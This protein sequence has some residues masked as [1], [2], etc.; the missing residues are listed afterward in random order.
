MEGLWL[1]Q[2]ELE[3]VTITPCRKCSSFYL[4]NGGSFWM[5]KDKEIIARKLERSYRDLLR[6]IKYYDFLFFMLPFL[7]LLKGILLNTG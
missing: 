3:G 7:T 5:S 6:A 2:M 4:R 1:W